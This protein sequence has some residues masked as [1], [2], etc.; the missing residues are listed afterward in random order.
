MSWIN[1]WQPRW[2]KLQRFNLLHWVHESFDID[3]FK[4][5]A[6]FDARQ[7]HLMSWPQYLNKHWTCC[8]EKRH[9]VQMFVVSRGWTLLAS[10]TV[11]ISFIQFPFK[12]TN[13]TIMIP[14]VLEKPTTIAVGKH[15]NAIKRCLNNLYNLFPDTPGKKSYSDIP[16]QLRAHKDSY[17]SH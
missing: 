17:K 9:F 16:N 14:F 1:C 8:W 3:W 11:W 10:V 12:I 2:D 4:Y 13:S 5:L 15:Y 6:V 7:C